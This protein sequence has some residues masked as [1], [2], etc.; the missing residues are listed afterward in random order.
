MGGVAKPLD[1]GDDPIFNIV[2]EKRHE[3]KKVWSVRGV[4][5]GS[6]PLDPPLVADP[7]FAIAVIPLFF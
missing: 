3:I 1:G 5:A 7:G 4:R 2:S 6:A